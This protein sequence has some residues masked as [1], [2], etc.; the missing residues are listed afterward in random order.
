MDSYAPILLFS[1]S[2]FEEMRNSELPPPFLFFF[3]SFSLSLI[4]KKSSRNILCSTLINPPF[5]VS[6]SLYQA[7]IARRSRG[8]GKNMGKKQFF[9]KILF[10]SP[11]PYQNARTQTHAHSIYLFTQIHIIHPF[12]HPPP[13]IHKGK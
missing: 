1:G 10:V 12:T 7:V 4:R 11:P 8:R 13:P 9:C 2:V 3:F 6:F 5:L